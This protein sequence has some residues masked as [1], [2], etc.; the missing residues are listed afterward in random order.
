M[1]KHKKITK[2]SNLKI[3][4]PA[5]I[6]IMKFHAFVDTESENEMNFCYETE[7]ARKYI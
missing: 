1:L 5:E 6:A 3:I 2:L 7:I 4:F